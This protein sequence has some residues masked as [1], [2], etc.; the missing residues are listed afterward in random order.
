[1]DDHPIDIVLLWVDGSDPEWRAHYQKHRNADLSEQAGGM[2]RYRDLGTLRYVLRSIEKYTPWYRNLF[3]VTSG[4]TPK[5]LNAAHPKLRCIPHHDFF[6]NAA[7][8]PTFN[9]NAIHANIAHIKGLSERFIV[10]DDDEI[11]IAPATPETFFENGLPVY[12]AYVS[13]A[14]HKDTYERCCID[15]M[16]YVKQQHGKCFTSAYWSRMRTHY[17]L[18]TWLYNACAVLF[19]LTKNA[20]PLFPGDFAHLPTPY[21]KSHVLEVMQRY[22]TQTQ[23]TS[24][25]IFR[26]EKDMMKW[27]WRLDALA[28]GAFSPGDTSSW[29]IFV[30]DAVQDVSDFKIYRRSKYQSRLQYAVT[31]LLMAGK[32]QTLCIQDHTSDALNQEEQ[33]RITHALTRYLDGFF[34][35]RSKFENP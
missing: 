31:L 13:A 34:P 29:Q 11:M 9:S 14:A 8:L 4:H 30:S 23:N 26:T 15:N 3:L 22:A 33:K 2:Q 20:G 35:E 32:I 6:K 25:Q 12:S 19:A 16:A 17:S 27:G 7:H 21:L 18:R 1:M 5:W 10:W 28:Q 24:A